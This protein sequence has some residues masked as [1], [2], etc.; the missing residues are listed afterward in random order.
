VTLSGGG[1][2]AAGDPYVTTFRGLTYKLPVIDAPIRYFQTIEEGK[3]LTINASLKTVDSSELNTNTVQSLIKLKDTMS[4][5]QFDELAKKAFQSDTLSFFETVRIQYGD[6]FLTLNVWDSTFKIVENK[7]SFVTEVVKDASLLAKSTGIYNKGYKQT[8]LKF[9]FG[10]TSVFLSVYNSP[11]VRNG[12]Y[13]T[14]EQE[15]NGVIVN[16][17][18]ES[19]MRLS[20]LSSLEPV[21]TVDAKKKKVIV[22][23]FADAEGLRTRNITTYH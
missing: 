21:S 5:R 18:S 17:L 16:A 7:S 20:S 15:G 22:E 10:T 9:Q 3:L 4:R 13:V 23:T 14:S 12:I 6:E 1:G 2:G 11:M 19:A 8:T